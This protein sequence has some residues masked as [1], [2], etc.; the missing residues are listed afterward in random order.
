VHWSVTDVCGDHPEVID[1]GDGAMQYRYVL[2]AGLS[3]AAHT[4]RLPLAANDVTS[5]TEFRAYKPPLQA[6]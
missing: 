2:G 3:D 1:E 6:N 5:V 4:A